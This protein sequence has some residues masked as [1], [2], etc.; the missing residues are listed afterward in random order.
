MIA[1]NIG[2]IYWIPYIYYTFRAHINFE[3]VVQ[4][5]CLHKFK[6]F[7]FVAIVCTYSWLKLC[8]C[9]RSPKKVVFTN[10]AFRPFTKKKFHQI[11]NIHTKSKVSLSFFAYMLL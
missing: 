2:Y 6:L 5:H 11:P 4:L 9:Q 7:I 8:K 1:C 3:V 10:Y